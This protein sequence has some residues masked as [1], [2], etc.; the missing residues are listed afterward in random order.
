MMKIPWLKVF[1]PCL[2]LGI[3]GVV[4]AQKSEDELQGT[5]KKVAERGAVAVGYRVASLP[6]SYLSPSGTPVGYAIDLC[7]E[8]VN[9]ASEQ[10]NRP[11]KIDWVPVTSASRI[12]AVTEGRVDIEC[13]STTANRERAQS[14]AFSPIMFVAGTRLLV[15]KQGGIKKLKDLRGKTIVVTSGTTNEQV[16]RELSEKQGLSLKV[17]TVPEHADAF[18]M[19][20]Q[21]QADAWAGDDV[22]LQGM[23]VNSKTPK[24]FMVFGEL[25]SYDPYGLMF[26]KEDPQW[27]NL[28]SQTF[29][30]LASTHEWDHIYT[31]WFMRPIPGGPRL[32]LPMSVQLR[33]F[34][35]ILAVQ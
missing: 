15:L 31:R 21:Q 25:L 1:L 30:R 3:S 29:M 20:V 11:L 2:I 9:A 28:V 24:A 14:V 10:L 33:S 22:L 23:L 8:V 18:E 12:Q 19:V 5:L 34:I 16:I 27:A 17:V 35:D 6:F 4:W 32:G 7:R 13:G 26:R